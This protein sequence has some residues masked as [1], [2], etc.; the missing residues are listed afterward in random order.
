MTNDLELSRRKILASAGV[1]GV[2]SAGAA[3]GTSAYFS[4]GAVFED[5]TIAAG[6]LDLRIDWQQLYYG[7]EEN[8][9]HYAPYGE[10]GYP[11]VNAH[12]DHDT[13]GMQSLDLDE[14]DEGEFADDEYVVTYMDGVEDPEEGANIQEYLTC[15][16]LANFEVPED[17]DNGVR[18]QD[19]LIELEDVKPG[20]CGEVTFSLHLCDN[21]GYIWWIGQKTEF[22]ED[23]AKAIKVKA[24]YDLECTNRFDEEDGDR[25]LV[26]TTDLYTFLDDRLTP[27]GRQLSPQPYGEGVTPD[28]YEGE[29]D[30]GEET[31]P[32]LF[33]D[34]IDFGD[35]QIT[36]DGDGM[37]L[38]ETVVERSEDGELRDQLA[39]VLWLVDPEND[40][41]VVLQISELVQK[42]NDGS[43]VLRE[44][45]DYEGEVI[46]FD[47]DILQSYDVDGE[48]YVSDDVGICRT[49]LRAGRPDEP[50][51]GPEF[52]YQEKEEC[53]TG[54][55]NVTSP[56]KTPG[57]SLAAFSAVEFYYCADPEV[58]P[59]SKCFP[60]EETFCVAFEWC[61]PTTTPSHVDDINDLQGQSVSFDLGFY[62]EQC[63]HNANPDGP[64]GF[65]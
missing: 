58:P 39:F 14:V 47:W 7:P 12:P 35:D 55:T 36:V 51:D 37:L 18:M 21:P 32:C 40:V 59:P 49:G 34:K 50:G 52:I 4:D 13:D 63:R 44:I 56:T 16:T 54:E 11:F 30:D 60:E 9:D 24:W 33:L 22:D 45:G 28:S 6:E 42:K 15:E 20:D 62:T 57:G 1:I 61:L 25:I 64:S 31:E 19:S 5:N 43:E 29:S 46:E 53:T 8:A 65:S 38:D 26:E 41:Q 17:F 2:A 27:D 3:F 10:A 48:T 23:L